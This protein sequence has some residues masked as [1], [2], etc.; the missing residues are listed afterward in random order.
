MQSKEYIQWAKNHHQSQGYDPIYSNFS[1]ETIEQVKKFHQSHPAYTKTPLYSLQQLAK[2]LNVEQIY[3]KDESQRF[4][5]NAFK[6]LGGVYAIAK[7]IADTLAIPFENITFED[8]KSEEVKNKLGQLTF[9]A[10]REQENP[11]L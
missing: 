3:A 4:G 5:L 10:F 8:L 11:L 7:Y 2:K 6:V 1:R 9:I